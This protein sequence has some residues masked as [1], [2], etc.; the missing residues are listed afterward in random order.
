MH[1]RTESTFQW[2]LKIL[3]FLVQTFKV[4]HLIN[5][6]VKIMH[7]FTIN[8]TVNSKYTIKNYKLNKS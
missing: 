7:L 4:K 8:Q 3:N 5:T 2:T 1:L 6:F